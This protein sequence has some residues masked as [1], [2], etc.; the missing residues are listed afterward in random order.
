MTESEKFIEFLR[1]YLIDKTSL[2]E[3]GVKLIKDKLDKIEDGG[4]Q[5]KKKFQ[6]YLDEPTYCSRKDVQIC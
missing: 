2:N 4:K 5:T 3:N 1:G 6:D